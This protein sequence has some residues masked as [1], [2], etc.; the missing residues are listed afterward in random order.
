MEINFDYIHNFLNDADY[1]KVIKCCLSSP[2]FYGEGDFDNN[3]PTGMISEIKEGEVYEI[4]KREIYKQVE[5]VKNL[6]LYRMYINCF[7]PGEN[8]YYHTDGENGITCLFY[9][10]PEVNINNGG[11]TEF[12]IGNEMVG[13]LPVPN[14]LCFFDANIL[15]R[16][17]S[18]KDRHRFTVAIKYE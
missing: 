17:T 9:V 11:S 7:A 8:P 4:F 1:K 2:Y 10:N 16:A 14:K 15:H 12:I 3:I 18:F 5:C 13:S 6:N